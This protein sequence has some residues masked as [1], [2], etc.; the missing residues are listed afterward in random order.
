MKSGAAEWWGNLTTLLCR[1]SALRE[2]G[3]DAEQQ[4]QHQQLLSKVSSEA[5]D[6]DSSALEALDSEVRDILE[7]LANVGLRSGFDLPELRQ[8]A[9]MLYGRASCKAIADGSQG[10]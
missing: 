2:N 5:L 7:W 9:Q 10:F 1:Y 6:P 8:R 4:R 3:S